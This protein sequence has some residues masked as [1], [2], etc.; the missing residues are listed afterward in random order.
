[1]NSTRDDCKE[2]LVTC[3]LMVM[4]EL[5]NGDPQINEPHIVAPCMSC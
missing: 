2:A 1:M 4:E 3:T 5:G